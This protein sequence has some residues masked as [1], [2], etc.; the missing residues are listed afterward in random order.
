MLK[1]SSEELNIIIHALYDM[2][3][4]A[5]RPSPDTV[6]AAVDHMPGLGIT[7]KQVIY[8][9]CALYRH[10]LS[11]APLQPI[12][13]YALAAHHDIHALAV[14]AS[15]YLLNL[16]IQAV[17]EDTSVRMGPLYLL[18]LIRLH[19][20]RFEALKAELLVALPTHAPARVD[21]CSFGQQQQTK[22]IWALFCAEP[23]WHTRQIDLAVQ[24]MEGTL[25]PMLEALTCTECELTLRKM[26]A[27]VRS[28]WLL[29]PVRLPP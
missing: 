8:P 6:A 13:V 3:L 1:C 11:F 18:K 24:A 19:A 21:T 26:V 9:G 17:S 2:S 28:Q 5:Y 23:M 14:Q 12:D 25:H 20:I 10:I 16:D 29:V 15:S 7:V 22:Q 27:R 4:D